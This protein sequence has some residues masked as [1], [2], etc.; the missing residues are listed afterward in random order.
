M[1]TAPDMHPVLRQNVQYRRTDDGRLLIVGPG[2]RAYLWLSDDDV[3]LLELFDGRA[4]MPD[5]FRR[6][7]ALTPPVAPDRALDLVVRLGRAGLLGEGGQEQTKLFEAVGAPS[8]GQRWA[9][10][11]PALAPVVAAARWVPAKAWTPMSVAALLAALVVLLTALLSGR[12]AAVLS[13][14]ASGASTSVALLATYVGASLALSA[15]AVA[16]A[17]LLRSHG[18]AVPA[19]GVQLTAGVLHLAF[20]TRE[21]RA[22]PRHVRLRLAWAGLAAVAMVAALASAAALGG[23]PAWVG[24]VAAAGWA[25]LLVDFAPYLRT[26][27]RDVLG[28]VTRVRGV[29]RG[30]FG[31]LASG[32]GRLGA[33]PTVAEERALIVS[34]TLTVVQ[35]ITMLSLLVGYVVPDA[36]QRALDALLPS[37]LTGIGAAERTLSVTVG[38]GAA[39]AALA[40]WVALALLA[41]R[42]VW[43]VVGPRPQRTERPLASARDDDREGFDSSAASQALFSGLG[44]THRA[45][46]RAALEVGSFSKGERLSAGGRPEPWFGVLLSGTATVRERDVSGA[47]LTSARLAPGDFVGATVLT[48]GATPPWEVVADDALRVA[49]LRGASLDRALPAEERVRLAERTEVVLALQRLPLASGLGASRFSELV[50]EARRVELAPGESPRSSEQTGAAL[51]LV[52]TGRVR[53]HAAQQ[54]AATPGRTVAAGSAFGAFVDGDAEIDR[55]EAIEVSS[56]VRVDA[57]AVRSMLLAN[58]DAPLLWDRRSRQTLAV[59]AVDRGGV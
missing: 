23:G 21:R 38:A 43:S 39:L 45:A 7:V 52:R 5:I 12:G 48:G 25:M 15:R 59:P 31:Y 10:M 36:I 58:L 6:A 24:S 55:I 57:E 9:W 37:Q 32:A 56:L 33:G 8:S 26:D 16:R 17:K 1:L 47:T 13:P 50:A 28:I 22:A 51:W 18:L 19:G 53:V 20:D 3:R 11:H 49:V 29:G 40:L 42:A 14:L 44:Q 2:E 41:A 54:L 4:A 46:L 34:A 27:L 35:T 30:A